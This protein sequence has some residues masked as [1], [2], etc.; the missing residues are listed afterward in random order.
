LTASGFTITSTKA[1]RSVISRVTFVNFGGAGLDLS[2]A[3]NIS[4][5]TVTVTNSGIGFRAA[6]NLAGSGVF[7]STFTN[8]VVGGMLL[9]A[10]NFRVGVNPVGDLLQSNTFTG[11]VSG[12]RGASTTG[13]SISGTSTGTVVKANS[14]SGYPTAISLITATGVRVGG[15]LAGEGNRINAATKAGIYASGFCSGTWVIKTTFTNTP[16]AIQYL[17]STSRNINIVK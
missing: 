14:F 6:N 7:N 11:S 15:T 9:N 12:F 5:D 3:R 8:N 10:Q 13:L 17:V 1:A 16:A 2:G 4:V